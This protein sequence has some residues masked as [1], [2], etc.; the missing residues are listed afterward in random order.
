MSERIGILGGTFNPIHLGHLILAQDALEQLELDQVCLIPCA[1][2]PHKDGRALA[3]APHRTAM[4][5][6]AIEGDPSFSISTVE[7][8][9][10]GLSWTVDTL[11]TL[12][13]AYPDALRV[14]IIG[15]DTV[16]ELHTWRR[17]EDIFRLCRFAVVGRPGANIT[18]TPAEL[19]LS[20]AQTAQLRASVIAGHDIDISSREI[21]MRIAEG[22][23]IR[24]LV[25]DAVAMY[26]A[27]HRLYTP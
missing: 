15:A 8:E 23:S 24:Y 6:A 18:G 1:L 2:P 26:I 19:R 12:H 21:R 27:E 22:L 4:I 20:K 9:R 17:I 13:D 5:E 25:P 7:I 16:H 11:Q 3:P 10:G 14:F